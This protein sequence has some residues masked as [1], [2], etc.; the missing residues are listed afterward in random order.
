MN[1]VLPD[2]LHSFEPFHFFKSI[3][4][5][6]RKRYAIMAFCYQ[7]ETG[8]PAQFC[9]LDF[10]CNECATDALATKFLINGNAVYKTTADHLALKCNNL[11]QNL[12]LWL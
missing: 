6:K 2:T 9:L 10:I 3:T 8:V 11:S 1:F 12:V 7:A 5:I 4:A